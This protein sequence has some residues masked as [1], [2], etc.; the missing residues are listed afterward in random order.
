MKH[1]VGYRQFQIVR[2]KLDGHWFVYHRTDEAL[3]HMLYEAHNLANAR[4]YVDGVS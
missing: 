3:E 1:I 4:E 2:F